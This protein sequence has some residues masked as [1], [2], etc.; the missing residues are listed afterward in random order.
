L[1]FTI[2]H[3]GLGGE[4]LWLWVELSWQRELLVTNTDYFI[5]GGRAVSNRSEAGKVEEEI[6]LSTSVLQAWC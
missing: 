6:Q 1:Y 2:S 3:I 5:F 4:R